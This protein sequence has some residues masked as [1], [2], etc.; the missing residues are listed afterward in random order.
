MI[1]KKNLFYFMLLP[2][3][4]MMACSSDDEPEPTHEMGDW[5]LDSFILINLPDA[6]S[7]NE[8]AVAPINAIS[9]GGVTFDSY[10]ITLATDNTFTR[11]IAIDG[12]NINDSGEWELA[13][14]RLTLATE[15]GTE[16][17]TVERNESDQLWLS[18]EAQF[19]F[20]P[21]IYFDTV[22]QTYID[23]LNTLTDAQLDSVNSSLTQA[24]TLDLVYAFERQVSN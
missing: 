24:V 21:D 7:S 18:E 15:D 4:L 13:S 10:D 19:G 5:S 23:F 20:I 2:L 11:R 22:T 17:F 14:G 3:V 9:F 6:F 8:N 1:M 16:E 12:P